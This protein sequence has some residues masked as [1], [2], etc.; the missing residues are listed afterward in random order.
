MRGDKPSKTEDEYFAKEDAEKK[1]RLQKKVKEERAHEERESTRDIWHMTCPKCGAKL[2]EIVFRGIKIYKCSECNGV[3]LDDG[4]LQ[5]L[6][7]PEE[8]SVINEFLK[9]FKPGRVS[10]D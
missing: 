9:L 8:K 4:E 3:W 6:A 10:P 2:S 1:K 7:G 5:K